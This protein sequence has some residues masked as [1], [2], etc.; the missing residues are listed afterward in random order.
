MRKEE[1]F[2]VNDPSF[3]LKKLENEEQMKSKVSRRAKITKIRIKINKKKKEKTI[4]KNNEIKS[5]L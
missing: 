3:Y 4:E 2:P 1:R 5:F